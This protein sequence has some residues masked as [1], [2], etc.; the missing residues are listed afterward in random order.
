MKHNRCSIE[1]FFLLVRAGLFGRT[2]DTKH[3]LQGDVDWAA[4]Y[5]LAK[6]QGVVGLVAEGVETLQCEKYGIN[7]SQLVPRE[8]V[9]RFAATTLRTEQRNLAMNTF[10]ANLIVW[11][12][13]RGINAFLLKGQ[14]VAQCYDKPLRRSC[15]DV[16]LLLN[17]ENYQKAKD[18]LLQFASSSAAENEYKKHLGMTINGWMIEL[19]GCLRCGFSARIDKEL[20]KVF[21]DTQ[22]GDNARTW[23]YKNVQIPLLE[24]EHDVLYVFIHFLNHFYKGGV[25]IK[26]ICDWCRQLWTFR[27][28]LDLVILET[29]LEK[30]GLMDEWRAFGMLSVEY[31]GMPQSAMPFYSDAEKWR[32]KARRI[33]QFIMKTGNMGRNRKDDKSDDSYWA[34]KTNSL[35][36]R[37][38]DLANHLTIFPMD[39]L[40]FTPSI[41]LNGL[42]QK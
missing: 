32:R 39:T 13:K 10:V 7:I 15:G 14:G 30:T 28:S 6:E 17:D 11:M 3:L 2:E 35:G 12:R 34:R 20:D 23:T 16:D 9:L 21:R 1:T 31:L 33:L 18:Y 25:G 36:Q 26:Q 19:H 27:D 38:C 41:L 5:Q 40:R 8:W 22:Y 24:R 29:W 42:R 4:I 37:I